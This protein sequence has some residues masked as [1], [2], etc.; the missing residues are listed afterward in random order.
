MSILKYKDHTLSGHIFDAGDFFPGDGYVYVISYGDDKTYKIGY[1]TSLD[2]RL[3]QLN[4]ASVVMP[5]E[6]ELV[7]AAPVT[8][9]V[10]VEK[11]LHVTHENN[12]VRG[13]WFVLDWYDLA[14]VANIL[15]LVALG[16]GEIVW[17]D[18]WFD[19]FKEIADHYGEEHEQ[20]LRPSVFLPY[21]RE[22]FEER[23]EEVANFVWPV[24]GDESSNSHL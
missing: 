24:V 21:R 18:K 9:C 15:S 12:R 3:A 1:T 14:K 4:K 23:R 8:G 6:Y 5:Y 13:E 2:K 11:M 20:V 7:M 16:S 17:G 10:A 22:A 19:V